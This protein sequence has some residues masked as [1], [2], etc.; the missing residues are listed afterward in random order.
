MTLSVFTSCTFKTDYIIETFKESIKFDRFIKLFRCLY[1]PS[2]KLAK[3]V[4][5]LHWEINS[6]EI[7]QGILEKIEI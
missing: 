7:V 5:D 1:I 3:K 2:Q 4:Q 6:L